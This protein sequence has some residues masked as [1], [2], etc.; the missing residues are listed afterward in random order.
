MPKTYNKSFVCLD[1]VQVILSNGYAHSQVGSSNNY[2]NQR[3]SVV[4]LMKIKNETAS[5]NHLEK[6]SHLLRLGM[7]MILDIMHTQG[8]HAERHKL[9]KAVSQDQDRIDSNCVQI[10]RYYGKVQSGMSW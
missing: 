9:W 4:G 7:T 8:L 10:E 3:V 2:L 6:I 5:K 1:F